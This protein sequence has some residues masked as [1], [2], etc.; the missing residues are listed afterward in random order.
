MKNTIYLFSIIF[1][2]SSCFWWN[3]IDETWLS[4]KNTESFS[5]LVPENWRDIPSSEMPIPKSGEIVFLL[6]SW[7]ERQW[8]RNNIVVLKSK[9]T[10][11]ESSL[12]LMKNNVNF[13]SN[14]L[15]NFQIITEE[16]I[17]FQDDQ[18]WILLTFTWKYNKQTP[19]IVYLQTARSCKDT[20][21]F[22]TLSL[23]EKLK[24]YDRY[25]YLLKSFKCK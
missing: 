7:E 12:S 16:N 5:M 20:S 11:N 23:A 17:N 9:N 10:K 19:E 15:E 22:I 18:A 1:I 24:S 13:L 2:L 8:Y 14:S 6:S 4:L 25:A 21:Y 3:N